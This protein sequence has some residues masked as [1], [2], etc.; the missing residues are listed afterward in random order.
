MARCARKE[1]GRW[2]PDALVHWSRS[3]LRLNGDWYC[4]SPCLELT[5]RRRL[6]DAQ[7]A[8]HAPL[9]QAPL[10]PPLKLGVLLMHQATITPTILER[11]LRMQGRTRLPLGR[12]LQRLGYVT[13]QDVLRA[14]AAQAGVSYLTAVDG[15]ALH[16]APGGLSR[17]TVRALGLVPIDVDVDR[18]RMKV[19]C[20]APLPRL[21]LA[22]MAHL[23]GRVIEPYFVADEDWPAVLAAYGIARTAARN[24][25]A[26]V[27]N[28]L[29]AAAHVARA[30][31]DAHDVR[32]LHARCDPY[33]WVRLEAGDGFEDMLLSVE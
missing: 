16:P 7:H 27:E 13:S 15:T 4:S 31:R 5:A 29:D 20:L 14:L 23:T 26:Q 33:M 24:A 11:G 2:R 12:Q 21:A 8:P 22:A 6:H 25:A 18:R 3:G 32:L 9:R 28:V 30:A 1:C 17:E 19:A 10:V